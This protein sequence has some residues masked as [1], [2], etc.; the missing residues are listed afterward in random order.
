MKL[1]TA[2]RDSYTDEAKIELDDLLHELSS[3]DDEQI[4]SMGI[5]AILSKLSRPNYSLTLNEEA[6]RLTLNIRGLGW[7]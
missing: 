5:A 2:I 3:Y 7:A 1:D 4:R 6:I